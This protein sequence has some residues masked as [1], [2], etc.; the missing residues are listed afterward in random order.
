MFNIARRNLFTLMILGLFVVVATG[1]NTMQA[2]QRAETWT[3]FDT[4][5][6]Q[7]SLSDY[8]GQTVLL[9][10]W[11]IDDQQSLKTLTLLQE[12]HEQFQSQSVAVIGVETSK[13][14]TAAAYLAENKFTFR[15]LLGDGEA[16]KTYDVST[17]PTFIII[18]PKGGIAMREEGYVQ[19]IGERLIAVLQQQLRAQ[20][21]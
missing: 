10:F 15:F 3:L 4:S 2:G 21:R 18:S 5:N 6:S 14:N 13:S 19:G 7:H 8:A 1:C 20:G 11:S 16:A 12:L 17:V 9:T